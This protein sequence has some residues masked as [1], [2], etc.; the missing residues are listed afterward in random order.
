MSS[1]TW[2]HKR[3]TNPW[4]ATNLN[5]LN[6]IMTSLREKLYKQILLI[7]MKIN[8]NLKNF[9]INNNNKT[10]NKNK[11]KKKI[12]KFKSF[13]ENHHLNKTN[14]MNIIKSNNKNIKK[15][16]ILTNLIKWNPKKWMPQWWVTNLNL[17]KWKTTFIYKQYSLNIR[18]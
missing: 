18:T 13:I 12:K 14:L 17:M 10:N 6:S 2:N 11:N 5:L 4:W 9:M 3:W 16:P 15:T 1:M 8:N 7:F